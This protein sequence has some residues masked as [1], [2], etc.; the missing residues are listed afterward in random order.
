MA[1]LATASLAGLRTYAMFCPLLPGIADSP[2]Q[3]DRL[4]KF[5]ADCPVEEVFVEPVN[6]RGSGL[7]LCQ[8]ALELHGY[9]NEANAIARVRHQ[10][11][12]S[13]YVLQLIHNVQQ[14]MRKHLDI[15]KLRFLLYPSRLLPEH[16]EQIRTDDAGVIWL[17][18]EQA[19]QPTQPVPMQQ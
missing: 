9:Q 1:A 6:T 12:W 3:I 10:D 2:E 5:A 4:V 7:R 15:S 17:R 18:R 11:G 8:E 13:D 19:S 16:I 14:S